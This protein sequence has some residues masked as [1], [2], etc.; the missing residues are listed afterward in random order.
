MW[1]KTK[2]TRFAFCSQQ[3]ECV[4]MSAFM[5]DFIAKK[6]KKISLH[7]NKSVAPVQNK[8]MPIKIHKRLET[9]VFWYQ[10]R[11]YENFRGISCYRANK[12]TNTTFSGRLISK[13]REREKANLCVE[14][15]VFVRLFAWWRG[16]SSKMCTSSC[17][18]WLQRRSFPTLCVFWSSFSTSAYQFCFRFLKKKKE[19]PIWRT[20]KLRNFRA[21]NSN[22]TFPP[23]FFL[24]S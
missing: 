20:S 11:R 13:K 19:K 18:V 7:K 5:Y 12:H 3:A 9:S 17:L 15:V 23:D 21:S 22:Q 4:Q 6:K 24:F 16:N 2:M 10:A 14:N 1:G 8:K